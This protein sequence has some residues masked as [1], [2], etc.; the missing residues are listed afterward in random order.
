MSRFWSLLASES[1]RDRHPSNQYTGGWN[2]LCLISINSPTRFARRGIK[3]SPLNSLQ[4]EEVFVFNLLV[5]FAFLLVFGITLEFIF[6]IFVIAILLV[7][8]VTLSRS[9]PTFFARFRATSLVSRTR[10]LSFFR[11]ATLFIAFSASPVTITTTIAWR[12][13]WT[14]FFAWRW[15][16]TSFITRWWQ[17]FASI[18]AWWCPL[19]MPWR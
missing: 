5:L 18:V 4:H 13:D 10:M 6:K 11:S 2:F 19:A 8:M 3:K 14:T 1:Q 9:W 12:R 7:M 16:W 15:Y 17:F